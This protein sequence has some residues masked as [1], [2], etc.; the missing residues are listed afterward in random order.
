MNL[1]YVHVLWYS[2]TSSAQQLIRTWWDKP[3]FK[4]QTSQVIYGCRLGSVDLATIRISL[5]LFG[6]HKITFWQAV[7]SACKE[8]TVVFAYSAR[9]TGKQ[10]LSG[11]RDNSACS[12]QCCRNYQLPLSEKLSF[13]VWKRLWN[14]GV[15]TKFKLDNSNFKASGGIT[16]YL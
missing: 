13:K 5:R 10:G 8:S 7:L 3:I 1:Q 14:Y 6:P 15:T 12:V 16:T 11:N 4:G 2:R 9:D